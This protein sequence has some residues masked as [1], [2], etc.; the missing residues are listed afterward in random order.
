MVR[1]GYSFPAVSEHDAASTEGDATEGV[2]G[3]DFPHH[4]EVKRYLQSF[5]RDQLAPDLEGR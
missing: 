5:V 1:P 4:R 2:W 3:S